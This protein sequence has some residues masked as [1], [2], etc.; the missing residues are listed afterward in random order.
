MEEPSNIIGLG[1]L[2]LQVTSKNNVLQ[3]TAH[4]FQYFSINHLTTLPGILWDLSYKQ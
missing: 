1:K 4:I 3:N 2:G